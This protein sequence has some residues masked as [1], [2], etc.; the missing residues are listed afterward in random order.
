MFI[1]MRSIFSDSEMRR[2]AEEVRLKQM[3][4]LLIE[5]HAYENIE[6]T[7]RLVTDEDLCEF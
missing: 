7:E 4:V 6:G 5:S 1:N 3:Y 2:F